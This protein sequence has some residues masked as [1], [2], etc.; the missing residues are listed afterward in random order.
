M[1]AQLQHCLAARVL[2]V[3]AGRLVAPVVEAAAEAQL[4]H[5]LGRDPHADAAE[6]RRGEPR[7][8]GRQ[9]RRVGL[10]EQPRHLAEGEHAVARHVV[11]AGSLAGHGVLERVDHFV[12]VHELV[13]RVEAQD[14]RHRGQREEVD[15]GR[16]DARA[17]HVREAEHGHRHLGF[18]SANSA[19]EASASTRRARWACAAGWIVP[20]PRRRTPGRPARSRRSGRRT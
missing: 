18:F 3:E 6:R 11:D 10:A 14:H 1:L 17:E 12:L 5:R 8:P 15:V 16:A 4:V 9:D 19:T 20:W 2:V 13:A 7:A